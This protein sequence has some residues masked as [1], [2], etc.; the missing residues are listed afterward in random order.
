MLIDLGSPIQQCSMDDVLY[1]LSLLNNCNTDEKNHEIEEN[2]YS[3]NEDLFMS[4]KISNKLLQQI[5]DPL[6][7]ASNGL[8]KWCEDLNYSSP[9]LFPFETRQ[10]YFNCTSFGTSR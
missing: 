7:L 3:L 9:F 1:L 8:P 6:V 10:L 5:Q 4:K 2:L